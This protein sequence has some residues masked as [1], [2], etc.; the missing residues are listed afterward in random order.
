MCG[1]W[2]MDTPVNHFVLRFDSE[3]D[4]YTLLLWVNDEGTYKPVAT[5]L[6]DADEV[7]EAQRACL[8]GLF[9]DDWISMG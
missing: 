2:G 9:G 6:Q 7:A 5:A 3:T 8:Q 4:D 1:E